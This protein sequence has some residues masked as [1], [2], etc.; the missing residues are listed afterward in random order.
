MSST[1][2]DLTNHSDQHHVLIAK[3]E[4]VTILLNALERWR[5]DLDEGCSELCLHKGTLA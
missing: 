3:Q 5:W 2:I 1:T 4:P